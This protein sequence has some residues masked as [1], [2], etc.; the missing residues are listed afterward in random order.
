MVSRSVKQASFGLPGVIVGLS[1][2]T[3]GFR[4]TMFNMVIGLA[5]W[6]YTK[7]IILRQDAETSQ[8]R[9][10]NQIGRKL[11]AQL[12]ALV[13]FDATVYEK[14]AQIFLE[15]MVPGQKM[16]QETTNKVVKKI[17]F[18][19]KELAKKYHPDKDSSPMATEKMARLN[20]MKV[21][22]EEIL[23]QE[24]VTLMPFDTIGDFWLHNLPDILAAGQEVALY[25]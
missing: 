9:R 25:V 5:L 13:V 24:P 4:L 10:R 22:M 8:T 3:V 12:L 2:L 19:Y 7:T 14:I 17:K 1:I 15:T 6:F 11:C 23:G 20:E 21:N 16:T 18:V